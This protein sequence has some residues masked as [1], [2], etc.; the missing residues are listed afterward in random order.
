MR[1]FVCLIVLVFASPASGQSPLVEDAVRSEDTAG[2]AIVGEIGGRG[3][4]T[5]RPLRDYAE[6]MIGGDVTMAELW[7]GIVALGAESPTG[8]QA[9]YFCGGILLDARTILTAAH[10]LDDAVQDENSNHWYYDFGGARRWPLI[11]FSN[12]DDLSEDDPRMVA[13]VIGGEAIEVPG[14]EYEVDP[15]GNQLND[16]AYLKLSKDLPG[17]YAR[18]AGDSIADPTFEG[19]LLWAAGFGTTDANNM[20]L[21]PF[22]SARGE[23]RTRAAS[24]QLLDAIVQYKPQ[25][26]CSRAMGSGIDSRSHIC[27]GWDDGAHDSCQGDSGGPLTVLDGEGCP[28]VVGL[29]SFGAECGMPGNYGVY[30]RVSWY[31]DWI[32][33]IAPSTTFVDEPPPAAGQDAF[34]R[35]VDG[36]VQI[37][38]DSSDDIRMSIRGDE[39]SSSGNLIQGN[40]Y[41]FVFESLY[42]ANVMV[43]SENEHGFYDLLFPYFKTDRELI[44]P[45]APVVF[46]FMA[47]IDDSSAERETG[48]L[49]I[50]L[51]PKSLRVRDVFLSPSA[52]RTKSILSDSFEVGSRLSLWFSLVSERTRDSDASIPTESD[53]RVS[54]RLFDYTIERAPSS[55]D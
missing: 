26:V 2:S 22:N 17:P 39:L 45:G 12:V 19:H 5:P 3:E 47:T 53:M 1:Y 34:K 51:L 49:R 29:T 50:F 33:Q 48:T 55:S 37:G 44:E 8:D 31:R 54:S 10:C 35:I 25:N 6:K 7:P 42:A 23:N 24:R 43:V 20:T 38:S 9:F 18:L 27:A 32:A 16:I 13:R 36:L 11:V 21:T 30:T 4:C 41:E 15:V 40:S 14:Q 52:T 46:G 28:V